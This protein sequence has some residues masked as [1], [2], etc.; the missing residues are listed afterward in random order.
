MAFIGDDQIEEA[1]GDIPVALHHGL[2]RS[3]VETLGLIKVARFDHSA[4]F[5]EEPLKTPLP[6]GLIP[7]HLPVG[8]KENRIDPSGTDQNVDQSH[9]GPGLTGCR[10]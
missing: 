1:G 6:V 3:R 5:G 8:Q 7:E 4:G 10:H 2:D 9:G